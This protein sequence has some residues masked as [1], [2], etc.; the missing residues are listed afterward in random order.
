[1]SSERLLLSTLL[2]HYEPYEEVLFSYFQGIHLSILMRKWRLN[3]AQELDA[4]MRKLRNNCK[5]VVPVP[6]VMYHMM[7]VLDC[8]KGKQHIA[9][10]MTSYDP[11][12]PNFTLRLQNVQMTGLEE[13]QC[14]VLWVFACIEWIK[15]FKVNNNGVE[16]AKL[17]EMYITPCQQFVKFQ[18]RFQ[19]GTKTLIKLE[20]IMAF[21]Q[22]AT[23]VTSLFVVLM[24][25][26]DI[27]VDEDL[28]ML[29]TCDM[30]RK[31]DI[32]Y[33]ELNPDKNIP[34]RTHYKKI[35]APCSQVDLYH[36]LQGIIKLTQD[37]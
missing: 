26:I 19:S 25:I 36:G 7:Y 1:M 37:G 9:S 33:Q 17:V 5:R 12:C 6:Q 2:R 4:E 21:L 35:L 16:F 18:E 34:L 8:A 15:H 30:L 29:V 14:I 13:F 3:Y 24:R 23:T 31:S 10:V 22:Y 27:P 20:D 32:Y 28:L 11:P